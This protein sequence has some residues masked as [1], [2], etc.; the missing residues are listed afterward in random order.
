MGFNMPDTPD[1][2]QRI[3]RVQILT[4]VFADDGAFIARRYRRNRSIFAGDDH[5]LTAG[6]ITSPRFHHDAPPVEQV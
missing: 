4:I 2:I 6:H 5:G 1:Q 3:S